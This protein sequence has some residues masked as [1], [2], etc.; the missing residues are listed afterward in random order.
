[1]HNWRSYLQITISLFVI[2]DPIGAIPIF[3]SLTESH[4]ARDRRRITRVAALS[5]AVVLLASLFLGQPL[6]QFF[7]ISIASF[8]VAG[9]ILIMLMAI[10]MLQARHSRARHAP[11]EANEAAIKEDI[12][13]VPLAIPLIAG[14]GAIST[15]IIYAHQ[16][17]TWLDT[18]AL[19]I[20]SVIIAL[21]V[22]LALLLADPIK[23]L[24]GATGINVVTR[25]LGLILAAVAVEFIA[26]G[27]AQLL[28]GL[29]GHP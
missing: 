2:A 3:I 6:L 12:G 28:P 9:G 7:G 8:R 21:S 29:A 11:E 25:L 1:M 13:V 10:A 24:L 14:P 18:L 22:W 23:R 5:V 20:I 15:I 27:L 19:V 26:S 17:T 16:A 4:A